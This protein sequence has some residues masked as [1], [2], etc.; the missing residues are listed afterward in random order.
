MLVCNYCHFDAD[1]IL[2]LFIKII[3]TFPQYLNKLNQRGM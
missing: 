2:E 3:N 1:L